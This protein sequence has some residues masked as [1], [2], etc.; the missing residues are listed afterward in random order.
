MGP[1]GAKPVIPQEFVEIDGDGKARPLTDQEMN[2]I[3]QDYQNQK[4]DSKLDN[5]TN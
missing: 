2:Q 5:Q 4:E 1:Y 3:I